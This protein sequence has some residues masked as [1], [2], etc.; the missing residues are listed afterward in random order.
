MWTITRLTELERL[1]MTLSNSEKRF[2]LKSFIEYLINNNLP[3]LIVSILAFAVSIIGTL[4][5]PWCKER[6]NNKKLKNELDNFRGM[7]ENEYTNELNKEIDKS[8]QDSSTFNEVKIKYILAKSDKLRYMKENELI[9]VTSENQIKLIRL[10]EFTLTYYQDISSILSI[11]PTPS[12]NEENLK[13]IDKLK[14]N[15][16]VSLKKLYL[17]NIKKYVNFEIDFITSGNETY[18]FLKNIKEL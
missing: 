8:S 14:I 9:Y 12:A 17:K 15:A 6:R 18:E 16:L 13:E 3:S 4:I 10:V 5:I 2:K 7:L 1:E 11:Y